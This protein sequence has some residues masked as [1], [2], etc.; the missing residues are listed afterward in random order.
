MSEHYY[1]HSHPSQ[2]DPGDKWQGLPTHLRAVAQLAR[3]FAND[4]TPAQS[5][6]FS[7]VAYVAGLMH[8]L[9]KYD[10]EFQKRIQGKTAKRAPHAIH[11][12]GFAASQ[13]AIDAALAIA[14]HHGGI[15]SLVA[16]QGALQDCKVNTVWKAAAEDMAE[17]NSLV[18]PTVPKALRAD[19]LR[20]EVRIRLLYSC[21]VDAD[22][23]DTERHFDP[24]KTA[25]RTPQT[26]DPEKRLKVLRSAIDE[27]SRRSMPDHVRDARR[28]VFDQ[29]L[30]AAQLT[31]GFFSLTV[32]TGGAKTLASMGHALQHAVHYGLRRIIYVLPYLNIIE[33]NAEVLAKVFG[34]DFVLEH[35]SLA[36]NDVRDVERRVAKRPPTGVSDEGETPRHRLATENWDAPLIVTTNVQF[37]DSL[38][39]NRPS[40]CRKLH[41]I[42]RSVV[43]LDEC[44]TLPPAL[45]QP[46]LSM[47]QTLVSDYGTTVV[48]CTATQPAF[49]RRPGFEAGIPPEEIREMVPDNAVLFQRLQRTELVWPRSSDQRTRWQD[50]A[51]GLAN[52]EQV[53]CIVNLR[54]H[55][56]ELYDLVMQR[57]SEGVFHLSTNLCP[58]H[59][60]DL[61]GQIR[62]RL[63]HDEPCRV[64]AT[65]LVEAGVDV[66][67]PTVFRA[68]GPFDAIAQ[69]AGRCNREGKLRDA[70]GHARYGRVEVFI[71]EDD[72]VP[73][74][75]YD[76]ATKKTRALLEHSLANG[77]AG[78][79]IHNPASFDDYFRRLYAD[80]A[81]DAKDLQTGPDSPRLA[82]DFPETAARFELIP[83]STTSVVVAY[84][85]E[86]RKRIDR[87][88]GAIT[89]LGFPPA[90]LMRMLQ[91]Y[92]VQ[93]WPHEV[94]AD[95][96][97]GRVHPLA[98]NCWLWTGTYDTALGVCCGE[99]VPMTPEAWI[100]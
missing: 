84:D 58:A 37:F 46:M 19:R 96:R 34:T 72:R 54:R 26:L 76:L 20:A 35:H 51:S 22:F 59:R 11:G 70:D 4:A 50:L 44:Q 9:G 94:T 18:V 42:A 74:G 23:L 56:A 17:L 31:P 60:L 77:Q 32:P 27:L 2:P 40:K 68:L 14:G 100:I 93:R 87:L 85:D 43:I 28:Y 1:A 15:P 47:L 95:Q 29:C 30:Q 12:A 67:F 36:D 33:Q 57:V 39:A 86:A 64:V 80:T 92:N 71:P 38:F 52:E 90:S 8:D 25:R 65:Q 62:E 5:V 53:L 82:L 49:R 88:R 91:R 41:R 83:Q 63:Q 45:L 97:D 78:P 61:L 21:L 3:Q 73:S 99:N 7:E 48:F 66:D 81:L 98:E 10:E 13:G 69:A 6:G 55:A 79:D 16:M 89:R 75:V 24:E